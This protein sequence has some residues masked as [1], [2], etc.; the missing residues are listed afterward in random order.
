MCMSASNIFV[1]G[2]ESLL[3]FYIFFHFY[4]GVRD[5]S[6]VDIVSNEMYCKR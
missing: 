1:S 6:I 5:T 2:D 4:S 3:R